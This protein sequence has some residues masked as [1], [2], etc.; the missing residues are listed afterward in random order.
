MKR[1]W[2]RSPI[3]TARAMRARATSRIRF[4]IFSLYFGRITNPSASCDLSR[5]RPGRSCLRREAT[6]HLTQRS[7][8]SVAMPHLQL[9]RELVPRGGE[10]SAAPTDA[11]SVGWRYSQGRARVKEGKGLH[12][13]R[14]REGF[15]RTIL[16]VVHHKE[17][18][19]VHVVLLCVRV[20]PLHRQTTI[21]HFGQRLE[22]LQH[23]RASRDTR[24]R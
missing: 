6:C 19:G 23:Q 8:P 24:R 3:H 1:A 2:P 9:Q 11:G 13:T 5:T 12:G 14:G 10:R 15:A 21:R 18:H 20:L 17:Q 4:M 22:P 16:V 7:T